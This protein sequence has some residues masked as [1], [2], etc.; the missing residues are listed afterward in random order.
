MSDLLSIAAYTTEPGVQAYYDTRRKVF[1]WKDK[2]GLESGGGKPTK[3]RNA[4]YYYRQAMKY[5]DLT[6]ADKYLKKY[7]ELGGTPQGLKQSIWMSH[8]LAGIKK[9]D[10]YSFR[11]ELSKKDE[12]RLGLA[13]NWY[14]KTYVESLR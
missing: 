4:L 2:H 3:K 9:A 6:A 11:N 1:D 14:Q 10:R 7:Y 12:K 13:L 5:G 8:P